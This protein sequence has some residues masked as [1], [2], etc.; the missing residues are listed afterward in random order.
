MEAAHRL[1]NVDLA[2]Q[3]SQGLVTNTGDLVCVFN[4][5]KAS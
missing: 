5:F 2:A 3:V 1:Q 4:G